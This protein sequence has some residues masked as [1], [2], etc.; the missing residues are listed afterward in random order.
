MINVKNNKQFFITFH[1]EI[2]HPDMQHY[3]I[4][5]NQ[6]IYFDITRKARELKKRIINTLFLDRIKK[7]PINDLLYVPK[8]KEILEKF[9]IFINSTINY[10]DNTKLKEF[11]GDND[12]INVLINPKKKIT[13]VKYNI[14]QENSNDKFFIMFE[15]NTFNIIKKELKKCGII[16]NVLSTEHENVE[17]HDTIATRCSITFLTVKN[18]I[19]EDKKNIEN[20]KNTRFNN[21]KQEFGT[22]YLLQEREFINK[23]ENV[24]KIGMTRHEPN[25]RL[26]KYPKN[27]QLFLAVACKNENT[28]D[29]ENEL[30]NKFKNMSQIVQRNDIGNEY[31][32]G[33]INLMMNEIFSTVVTN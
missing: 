21:N 1:L 28:C 29:I 4:I 30:I 5:Q 18:N 24:Y 3:N 12:F 11:C 16:I 6:S 9:E 14:G 22:I 26:S 19:I 27:S 15:D 20:L 32:Q 2:Y 25:K 31:F 33:N 8:E 23:N 7:Y 13:T 10:D 17:L